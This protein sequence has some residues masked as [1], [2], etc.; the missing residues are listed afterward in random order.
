V[1]AYNLLPY[2]A[3]DGLMTSIA[4]VAALAAFPTIGLK[5][6]TIRF[7]DE[8]GSLRIWRLN[9]GTDATADGV[10]Q[11]ADFNAGT[12]AKVWKRAI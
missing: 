7:V 6:N 9:A 8:A 3:G 11:P 12:N 4:S 2:V 10:Q 5:V 1:H